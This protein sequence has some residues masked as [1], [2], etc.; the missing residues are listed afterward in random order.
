MNNSR[1]ENYE[2]RFLKIK[3][4]ANSGDKV[5]LKLPMNFV[6]RIVKNNSIDFLKSQSD[7]IDSEKLL[8]I[9]LNAF[10]YEIVGEVAYF[11]RN[12]GDKIRFII[13]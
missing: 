11:E 10:D 13:D 4:S 6:K 3:I 5:Y 2:E 8:K 1:E 9:M 7:I 12:N